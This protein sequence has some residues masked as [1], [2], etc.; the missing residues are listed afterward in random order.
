[1]SDRAFMIVIALMMIWI[2]L[3]LAYR[4]SELEDEVKFLTV[5][6]SER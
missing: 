3:V 5:Q 1:M 2:S 6:W 4:V